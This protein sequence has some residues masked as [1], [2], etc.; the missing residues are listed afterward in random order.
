[1]NMT[2]L[3]TR[4]KDIVV[5]DINEALNQKENKNPI[6][7][8]NQYL[9]ECE[10]E[11]EKVGKLVVRQHQ[12][13]DEF[14]REYAEAMKMA[15]KRKYQAEVAQKAGETELY[16][17]ASVEQQCFEEQAQRLQGSLN[18]VTE[19]LTGLER[20]YEEMKR[21]V[22]DMEIRRMELMGR[23]NVTR[24]NLQINQVLEADAYADSSFSKFKEI[25]GY[26]DRLEQKVNRSFFSS[27]IDELVAKLEKKISIDKKE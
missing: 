9:R 26:L 3:F 23:E 21:K 27:T 19:Q 16:Q 15:E 5:A 13:R 2:N 8:L 20:K 24:A 4:I 1:M 25:E 11:T 22:K 14:V 6:A 18:Q 17:F 10:K 12:L 7:M